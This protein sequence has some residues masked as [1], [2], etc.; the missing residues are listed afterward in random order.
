[1]ERWSSTF[2]A[3]EAFSARALKPAARPLIGRI[4][5]VA[6]ELLIRKMT[7]GLS[8]PKLG[9]PVERLE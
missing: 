4:E 9:P 3:W 2:K 7:H 8:L 5:L 1:M 6:N